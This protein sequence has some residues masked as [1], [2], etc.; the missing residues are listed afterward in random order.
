MAIANY[1]TTVD[2]SKSVGE[3][4][5]LLAENGADNV[6]A[7]H[8]GG[9]PGSISFTMKGTEKPV[10]YRLD[11]NREGVLAVMSDDH[12]IRQHYCTPEHAENVAWRILKDWVR[13]QLAIINAG[14]ATLEQVMLP[15]VVT[16]SGK[17]LSQ[18]TGAN[19]LLQLADDQTKALGEG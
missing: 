5:S 16:S 12:R 15:F 1:S 4:L 8:G 10:T 17:I 19:T 11:A 7:H 2:A 3:I 13:A 18:Q 6:V 9:V 14:I